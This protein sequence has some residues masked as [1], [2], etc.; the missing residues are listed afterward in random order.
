MI[1]FFKRA[2]SDAMYSSSLLEKQ[3][4]WQHPTILNGGVDQTRLAIADAPTEI[5]TDTSVEN[6]SAFSFLVIGDTDAGSADN[7]D[8][9]F[10]QLFAQQVTAYLAESRFL[11]HTGDV[12]YPTGSYRNYFSYFL[13][14]YQALL[15][16]LPSSPSYNSRQIV[17]NKALLSVPGNHDYSESATKLRHW[18]H[19]LRILCD[20]LRTSIDVDLGCYG[21]ERGEAYGQTFLDDLAGL[22][23]EQL[24]T[25]LSQHYS[26]KIESSD[27]V[28]THCL[29]YQPGSFTRLPNRYY[30]FRYG[31]VDFFA[32][33]SNT[34][35]ASSEAL[36]FDQAQ[37]DWLEASLIHS[38]QT[39]NTIA[40]IVYLHHSPYTTEAFH[41][42]QP[43]TT[44]VRQHLR[45]V[46]NKVAL[47]I[48]KRE[49]VSPPIV[50][51]VLSGHAHCLEHL[52]TT[53]S[54][55]GDSSIDWV[56]CGGSGAS[57]RRQRSGEADILE[58]IFQRGRRQ[59]KVV[60]RSQLFVGRRCRQP[61]EQSSHSFIRV[62]VNP[63]HAQKITVSPFVVTKANGNW[64]TEVRSPFPVGATTVA[65]HY[66][67]VKV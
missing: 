49:K 59:A 57:V 25:H 18:K 58:N 29:S 7:S 39:P 36:G 5:S 40:R 35:N 20:R 55:Q 62:D 53:P 28:L 54:T 21:G 2:K 27:D 8:R 37:L 42:Q 30:T 52:K 15:K 63:Y 22:S 67:T 43:E 50:D 41:W 23:P 33:D 38:W 11:L 6:S 32:L 31:G 51:L 45:Q 64:R 16:Q 34:W 26:A 10:S 12:A 44:W 48:K 1:P 17:F 14:P 61:H 19:L 3:V 65:Q 47:T 46:F 60:A 56:V 4:Q 24:K 13:K 66:E 9:V